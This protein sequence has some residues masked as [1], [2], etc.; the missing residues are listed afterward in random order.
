MGA[1]KLAN[2][3]ATTAQA[4]C[5]LTSTNMVN[6]G[7]NPARA[8]TSKHTKAL[9]NKVANIATCALHTKKQPR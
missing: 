8:P 4:Q 9:H 2:S 5:L 3:L 6:A 1:V 7:S